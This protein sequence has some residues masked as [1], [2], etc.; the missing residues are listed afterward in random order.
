MSNS[1]FSILF[2]LVFWQILLHNVGKLRYIIA[3]FKNLVVLVS[4]DEGGDF[5]YAELL[6][7]FGFETQTIAVV[8]DGACGVLRCGLFPA[9]TLYV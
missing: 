1:D 9:I 6:Y 3:T 5:F 2:F 7:S 4:K 8:L